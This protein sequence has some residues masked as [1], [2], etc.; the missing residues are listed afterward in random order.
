MDTATRPRSTQLR[1]V[2]CGVALGAWEWDQDPVTCHTCG[3]TFPVLDGVLIA[4]PTPA[5]RLACVD[6]E[7][8]GPAA[9][10]YDRSYGDGTYGRGDEEMQAHRAS[11]EH[12]EARARE[13]PGL[14]LEIGA[15][16]G[17]CQGIGG[18]DYVGLD[19]SLAALL[20]NRVRL[21]I[22]GMAER[23]PLADGSCRF[24]YSFATFEHVSDPQAAFAE[25]DRVLAPGG[26]GL[27]RPA[28]HCRPWRQNVL[29][30][31]PWCSLPLP[32]RIR[33]AGLTVA[34]SLAGKACGALPFRLA[35][36]LSYLARRRPMPLAYRRLEPCYDQ[37]T[38]ADADA[39]SSL[40]CHEG[41]LYFESRGYEV[42]S[43][44]GVVTKLLAR[45]DDVVTRKPPSRA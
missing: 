34:L 16:I 33:K 19:C 21:G 7:R 6:G 35:R 40:D 10:F 20:S 15:G 44:R 22:V 24:V 13:V 38:V 42:L 43:H 2:D 39:T 28:W 3:A 41:I 25:V 9:P 29:H 31:G 27:L 26:V 1:C 8:T 5:E 37:P 32:E 23:L 45:H 11:A 36:R 14:V 4:L 12:W 17:A 30:H 18:E